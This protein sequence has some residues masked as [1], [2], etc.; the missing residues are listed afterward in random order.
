MG[1]NTSLNPEPP[2]RSYW[3]SGGAS[4]VA[5]SVIA[6]V[7]LNFQAAP[8]AFGRAHAPSR[9]QRRPRAIRRRVSCGPP[10]L[11]GMLCRCR[12]LP[13]VRR[14][15]RPK[16]RSAGWAA[17]CLSS[18]RVSSIVCPL[19]RCCGLTARSKRNSPSAAAQRWSLGPSSYHDGV[20]RAPLSN[21]CENELR[22]V[23]VRRQLPCAES[24][25]AARPE[26]ACVVQRVG[27]RVERR[28]VVEVATGHP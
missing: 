14:A 12:V 19:L 9:S 18:F 2:Q 5:W 17:S 10:A 16:A 6:S 25:G 23:Q 27:P 21:A 4:W 22:R 7:R 3:A 8:L 28:A 20:H 13:F 1:P 15:G 11:S 24:R 26:Q